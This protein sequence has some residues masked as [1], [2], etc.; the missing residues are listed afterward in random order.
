MNL[1]FVL[2]VI[3]RKALI[4]IDGVVLDMLG[5][6][7]ERIPEFK[8]ENV[9]TFDF[10]GNIGCSRDVVYQALRNI[11]TYRKERLYA[12][13]FEALSALKSA[14]VV[15]YGYTSM[16]E[17]AEL[18]GYRNFVLRWLELKGSC[19]VDEKP[20]LHG[21]DALFEDCPSVIQKYYNMPDMH[22]Y[23][24]DHTYNRNE[25]FCGNVIRRDNFFDAVVD[26]LKV[27]REGSKP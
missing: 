16:P 15:C 9:E 21:Y 8:P 19:F 11:E 7:K 4:D 6:L 24:I 14:G 25:T 12:A 10:G 17:D 3:M 2:G 23:L 18:L 1:L 13:S 22:I 5:A 26:Y 20:L 27:I